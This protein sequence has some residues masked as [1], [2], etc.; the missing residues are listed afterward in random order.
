MTY[1]SSRRSEEE[2]SRADEDTIRLL[3]KQRYILSKEPP[4]DEIDLNKEPETLR[5][6]ESEDAPRR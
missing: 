4:P 2:F 1:S 6:D 5:I 3:K